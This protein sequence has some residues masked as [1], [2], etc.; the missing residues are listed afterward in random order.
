MFGALP[1]FVF[2]DSCAPSLLWQIRLQSTVAPAAVARWIAQVVNTAHPPPIDVYNGA[3]CTFPHGT[4]INMVDAGHAQ[5]ITHNH[6]AHRPGLPHSAKL[7]PAGPNLS[8][9]AVAATAQRLATTCPE[10]VEAISVRAALQPEAQATWC[11]IVSS[12]SRPWPG[13]GFARH[14]EWF[15]DPAGPWSCRELSFGLGWNF[16][17]DANTVLPACGHRAVSVPT[18]TVPHDDETAR[19]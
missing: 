12:A 3:L 11:R 6:A 18:S 5:A 14:P 1:K 7:H 9:A 15:H 17:T 4:V 2:D 8:A 13:L 16:H 19:I 10:G